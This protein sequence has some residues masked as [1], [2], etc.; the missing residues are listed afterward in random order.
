MLLDPPRV[1]VLPVHAQPL[2]QRD[3]VLSQA[4]ADLM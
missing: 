2:G 1:Q 3:A 4:L